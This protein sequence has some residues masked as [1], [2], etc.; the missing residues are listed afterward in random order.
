M[1]PEPRTVNLPGGA[2][3]ALRV[4]GFLDLKGR[5]THEGRPPLPHLHVELRA[6]ARQRPE[7]LH[8]S[9]AWLPAAPAYRPKAAVRRQAPA[10]SPLPRG[11]SGSS[12]GPIGPSHCSD[13]AGSGW[14]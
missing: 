2:L 7:S 11:S 13:P 12:P 6:L 1:A 5:P 10:L 8:R 9:C 4:A 3:S 14:L